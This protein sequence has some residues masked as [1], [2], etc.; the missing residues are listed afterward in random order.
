MAI[1]GINHLTFATAD[2]DRS[3]KFYV[4]L[5]GCRVLATRPKG[6]YLLAGDPW[7]AL[8][9]GLDE[10][11]DPSDYSHIAFHAAPQDLSDIRHRASM[12]G[13]VSWQDNWTEGDSIYLTDPSGHRIEVHSTGAPE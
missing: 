12:A 7:L 5:L 1:E 2:L 3:L 8:V 13:V 10:T 4:E 11:R 6:A 9:Q